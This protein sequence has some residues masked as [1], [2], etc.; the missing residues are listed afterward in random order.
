MTRWCGADCV[1]PGQTRSSRRHVIFVESSLRMIGAGR[2]TSHGSRALGLREPPPHDNEINVRASGVGPRCVS[3][4]FSQRIKRPSSPNHSML[5]LRLSRSWQLSG[6]E[7]ERTRWSCVF[8]PRQGP[9]FVLNDQ[10]RDHTSQ[11]STIDL[12]QYSALEVD[13]N[14]GGS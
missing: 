7:H 8:P 10:T 11:K 1:V 14:R 4:Y 6:A 3:T 12:D 2:V 9:A 5:E 13:C